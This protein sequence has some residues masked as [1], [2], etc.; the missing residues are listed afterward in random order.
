MKLLKYM[1]IY[2]LSRAYKRVVNFC[3]FSQSNFTI[4]IEI[5]THVF[6]QMP[7]EMDFKGRFHLFSYQ[8]QQEKVLQSLSER[9]AAEGTQARLLRD[10]LNQL[11]NEIEKFR[12][13]NLLLA[14]LREE[15][16]KVTFLKPKYSFGK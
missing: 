8:E 15:R 10:K 2:V 6:L 1:Y 7:S 4:Q 5:I 14:K 11:E 13:E 9:P 3:G 16:E 12:K